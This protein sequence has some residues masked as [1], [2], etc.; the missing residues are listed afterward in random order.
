MFDSDA[1]SAEIKELIQFF[2]E[3]FGY[4]TFRSKTGE[5][6]NPTTGTNTPVYADSQAYMAG[7]EMMGGLLASR[8]SQEYQQE[9]MLVYVHG[10]DIPKPQAGDVVQPA[11]LTTSHKVIHADGDMFTIAWILHVQRKAE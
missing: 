6:Y 4:S 3:K 11:W 1:L 2:G 10:D 8:Y 7:D 5:S 9:N